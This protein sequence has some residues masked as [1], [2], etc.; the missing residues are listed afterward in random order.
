MTDQERKISITYVQWNRFRND[1]NEKYRMVTEITKETKRKIEK[2]FL[3]SHLLQ[4][5]NFPQKNVL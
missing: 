5:W 3:C 2:L 1:F 4:A